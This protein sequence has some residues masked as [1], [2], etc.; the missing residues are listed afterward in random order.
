M[1]HSILKK[2]TSVLLQSHSGVAEVQFISTVQYG[3]ASPP[4]PARN[5]SFDTVQ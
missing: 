1:Y 3:L 2:S 5:Q 4:S